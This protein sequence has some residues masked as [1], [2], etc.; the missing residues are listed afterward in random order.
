MSIAKVA[1][2]NNLLRDIVN[3]VSRRFP[4]DQDI[5]YT[6]TQIE[7]SIS[8]SPRLTISTFLQNTQPYLEK[9]LLKDERFF[10]DMADSSKVLKGLSLNHKWSSFDDTEKEKMWKN[11]QKMVVLGNKIMME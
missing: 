4:D 7:L 5:E 3:I 11:V 1:A 8:V 2:F 6:K 9:I 10:L